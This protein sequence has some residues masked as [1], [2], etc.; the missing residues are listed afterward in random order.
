MDRETCAW[1]D[2]SAN[3]SG[4]CCYYI[5]AASI[6]AV[7]RVEE[8]R[9]RLRALVYPGMLRLHWHDEAMHRR[10]LIADAV[11][12]FNLTHVSVISTLPDRAKEERARRKCLE[13]ILYELDRRHIVRAWIESRND[14]QDAR[15]L[16]M[17]EAVRG[18]RLISRGLTVD[19]AR[20]L[21]EPMLWLPDAV[22]GMTN[23]D[24]RTKDSFWTTRL[25]ARY[26]RIHL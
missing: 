24:E 7:T 8:V 11:S 18:R 16:D 12:R 10:R 26:H 17:V 22:A 19:F 2:E 13:R 4:P 23:S 21:H 25:G 15:D 20:P 1:I 6:C 3:T 9:Q 5:L 14:R